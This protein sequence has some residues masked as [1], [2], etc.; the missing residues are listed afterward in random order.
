M[1]GTVFLILSLAPLVLVLALL[2]GQRATAV[3]E[4][5]AGEVTGRWL[6]SSTGTY[7][8]TTRCV[9][10]IRDDEGREFAVVVNDR[11]YTALDVGDRVVKTPGARWPVRSQ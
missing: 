11:T 4:A 7:G 10:R 8:T 6:T 2:A 9:L 1:S 5:Y 3:D